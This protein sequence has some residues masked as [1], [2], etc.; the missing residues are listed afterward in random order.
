MELE[1]KE[2]WALKFF[3]FDQKV[4]GE[5]QKIQLH[6]LEES[7]LRAYESSR[8][9]KER[10]KLYHDKKLVKKVFSPGQYVLLSN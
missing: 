6:E 1:H 8:L 4:A 7:R 10:M 5:K 9:Y 3:N 2:Y